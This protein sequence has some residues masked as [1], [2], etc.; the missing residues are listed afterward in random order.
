MKT[1]VVRGA[2]GMLPKTLYVFSEVGFHRDD[3]DSQYFPAFHDL[4]QDHGF[5][6]CGLYDHFRWGDARRFAGFCS[7]LYLNRNF[8][9]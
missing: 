6:L 1:E 7:A 8:S 9:S 5:D 2:V 3:G 4:M